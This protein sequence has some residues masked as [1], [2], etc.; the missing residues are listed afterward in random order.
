[1]CQLRITRITGWR[2]RYCVP[3]LKGGSNS[4]ENRV[5][6]HPE[7]HDRVH[8]QAFLYL[9]R[10]SA[11]EAF[12]VLEPDD[13]H[14]H[15]RFLEGRASAMGSGYSISMTASGHSPLSSMVVLNC[16]HAMGI[17]SLRSLDSENQSLIRCRM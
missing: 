17:R 14:C 6:L 4:A 3:R 16:S 2:L 1:V 15:V 8:R 12:E 7:C 13:G 9:N 11:T 5:L 10:V